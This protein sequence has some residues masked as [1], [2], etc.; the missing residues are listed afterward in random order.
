MEDVEGNV[1]MDE[2][3]E[4]LVFNIANVVHRE[5]REL[6]LG[7]INLGVTADLVLLLTRVVGIIE[8]ERVDED[9][10]KVMLVVLALSNSILLVNFCLRE[11]MSN[12]K[13]V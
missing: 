1:K 3:C 8:L 5:F 9:G 2:L 12:A 11:E 6:V 4:M 7:S 13:L 10:V